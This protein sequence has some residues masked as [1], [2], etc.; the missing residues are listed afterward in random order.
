[1]GGGRGLINA[2][3]YPGEQKSSMQFAYNWLQDMHLGG[4][5]RSCIDLFCS[6]SVT[7]CRRRS[8]LLVRNQSVVK[9][10]DGV[11]QHRAANR[12]GQRH[13]PAAPT[14]IL[15]AFPHG[16]LHGECDEQGEALYHP[17]D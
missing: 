16:T 1:M 12:P 10:V 17:K 3:L 5:P 13:G 8:R 2:V 4:L 14:V 6:T 15:G 11:E 7:P 9:Q